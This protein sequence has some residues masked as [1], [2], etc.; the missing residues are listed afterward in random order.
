MSGSIENLQ[1][2][3]DICCSEIEKLYLVFNVTLYEQARSLMIQVVVSVLV[4]VINSVTWLKD[5]A[6]CIMT[7]SF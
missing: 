4:A 2:M 6:G 5:L 1:L 7:A 3:T